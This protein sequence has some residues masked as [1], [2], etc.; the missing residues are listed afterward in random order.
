[1]TIALAVPGLTCMMPLMDSC[2]LGL[3]RLRTCMR[4][5]SALLSG[6]GR[7]FTGKT[8]HGR[9][10]TCNVGRGSLLVILLTN[11]PCNV[12]LVV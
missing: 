2:Y 12:S 6:G 1:M 11:S 5:F 3:S 4:R 10:L 9:G 8:L 7:T